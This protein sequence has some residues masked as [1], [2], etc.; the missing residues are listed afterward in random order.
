MKEI[1]GVYY[2]KLN[3]FITA[4]KT[5]LPITHEPANSYVGKCFERWRLIWFV[6]VL[7]A[8]TLVKLYQKR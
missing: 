3:I 6:W 8:I 4:S 7:R 2:E 1:G 5:F